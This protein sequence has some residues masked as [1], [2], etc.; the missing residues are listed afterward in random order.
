MVNQIVFTSRADGK[1]LPIEQIDH[2]LII[3]IMII[4][5]TRSAAPP[6]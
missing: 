1:F 2:V 5:T 3:V 6:Q 4:V